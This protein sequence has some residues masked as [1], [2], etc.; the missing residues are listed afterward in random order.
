MRNPL[1]RALLAI[2]LTATTL[3][4][5]TMGLLGLNTDTATPAV[6]PAATNEVCYAPA[7]LIANPLLIKSQQDAQ[8]VLDTLLAQAA[9]REGT[10]AEWQAL[11][12]A[13]EVLSPQSSTRDITRLLRR[14]FYGDNLF[15]FAGVKVAEGEP[16]LSPEL[17]R[18][19][20]KL[21]ALKKWQEVDARGGRLDFGH[22]LVALDAYAWQPNPLGRSKAWLFTY[23]G[24]AATGA[25]SAIG[26]R[27]AGNNN[28]PDRRGNDL[29]HTFVYEF[30]RDPNLRL[31]S[32][33]SA[34]NAPPQMMAKHLAI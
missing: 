19:E 11:I 5:Q 6:R 9:T 1:K 29:G 34:T 18:Y 32:L 28:E 33:V 8:Q 13:M 26:F 12:R 24:D 3:E 2:L 21:S 4:A 7:V 25:A 23:F 30:G 14:Q 31:S 16:N 10:M 15:E 22:A 20:W 27:E 17:K